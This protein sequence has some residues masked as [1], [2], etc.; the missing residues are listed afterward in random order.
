MQISRFW[1]PTFLAA[2]LLEL[3]SGFIQAADMSS[4]PGDRARASTLNAPA[5]AVSASLETERPSAQ[6][7][8]S[9]SLV[10]DKEYGEQVVLSRKANWEPW[11]VSADGGLYFTDNAALTSAQGLE[12]F[13]LRSGFAAKYTNRIGGNWFLSADMDAH[14]LQYDQFDVLDFLLVKAETAALYRATWL[15]DAYFSLGYIGHWISERDLTTEAFQSHGVSA[16]VQKS[17]K[18]N[19]SMSLV[20][21]A[22]V[23]TTLAAEPAPPARDEYAA[24]TG[25]QYRFTERFPR[26]P[27]IAGEFGPEFLPTTTHGAAS[28]LLPL[29]RDA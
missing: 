22:N 13:Y 27:F 4:V 5:E 21:G 12:D 15:A 7:A 14:V 20:L 29:V 2:L 24:Y 28:I 17:W 16:S 3:I 9:P 11:S 26:T 25:F 8:A 1:L 23:I 18:L 10:A 6:A 19:R